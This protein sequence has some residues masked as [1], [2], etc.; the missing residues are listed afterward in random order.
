MNKS[1]YLFWRMDPADKT[2][3]IYGN[4]IEYSSEG[5]V[6]ESEKDL[7][8]VVLFEKEKAKDGQNMV[9]TSDMICMLLDPKVYIRG[10]LDH[11]PNLLG[12]IYNQSDKSSAFVKDIGDVLNE[13]SKVSNANSNL[14]QT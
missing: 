5:E 4:M 2:E 9:K 14:Q 6:S 13:L 10:L 12:I 7:Y 11:I 8:H 3:A 1:N